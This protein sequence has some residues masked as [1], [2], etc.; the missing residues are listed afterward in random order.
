MNGRDRDGFLVF[1]MS[2]RGR[3]RQRDLA[4]LIESLGT[5]RA[6]HWAA[7]A[8][9]LARHMGDRGCD[10]SPVAEYLGAVAEYRNNHPVGMIQ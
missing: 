10:P 8:G 4:V 2:G 5:A 9:H 6:P 3:G 7:D 1:N